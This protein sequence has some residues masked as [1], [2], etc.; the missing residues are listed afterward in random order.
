MRLTLVV[1]FIASALISGCVSANTQSAGSTEISGFAEESI[2]DP[3]DSAE[4]HADASTMA[5]N[6]H[7]TSPG[8][9]TVTTT[10]E[11]SM[12]PSQDGATRL[13]MAAAQTSSYTRDDLVLASRHV[14]RFSRRE[15]PTWPSTQR[16][17]ADIE[18]LTFNDF[19]SV[20]TNVGNVIP[21]LEH[22][23]P[24]VHLPAR[25]GR[26]L[27]V[28]VLDVVMTPERC[29]QARSGATS[30]RRPGAVASGAGNISIVCED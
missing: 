5:T 2:D 4:L 8:E 20:T 7:L 23:P 12:T 21:V 13:Q 14:E 10:S 6:G 24:M 29:R 3:L 11:V 28:R 15:V 27:W 1:G 18:R 16:A 9:A 26:A 22:V 17:E 30:Q 19:V 25:D